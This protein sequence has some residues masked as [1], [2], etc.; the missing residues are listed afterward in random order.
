MAVTQQ[1][2]RALDVLHTA[3]TAC[4]LDGAGPVAGGADGSAA[5]AAAGG[6]NPQQ[7]QRLSRL[8]EEV[9]TVLAAVLQVRA[10]V[11]ECGCVR[12]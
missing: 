9:D 7:M 4:A 3:A 5:S 11:L 2:L 10:R 6:R 8:D 12:V 1:A